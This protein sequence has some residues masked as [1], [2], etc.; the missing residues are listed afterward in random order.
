MKELFSR[1]D[2]DGS[3]S[4]DVKEVILFMKALTDDLSEENITSIFQKLDEDQSGCIDFD[5]FMVKG[6]NINMFNA[7][8]WIY[9][10]G[11]SNVKM[12]VKHLDVPL[13][14]PPC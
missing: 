14:L 10:Y 9:Q 13:W 1:I 5:E 7:Y 3:G 8:Q 2:K 11:W 4:L 12:N 6:L